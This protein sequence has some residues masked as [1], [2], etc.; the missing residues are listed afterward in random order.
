M[1]KL[2]TWLWSVGGLAAVAAA[3]CALVAALAA[4]ARPTAGAWTKLR[5]GRRQL[6]E[7]SLA[8]T[9]TATLHV[10]YAQGRHDAGHLARPDRASG[11][12]GA[13][14]PDRAGLGGRREPGRRRDPDGAC[15][16]SGAGIRSLDPTKTNDAL[17]T[18]VG[19]GGADSTW[20]LQP[21]RV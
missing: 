8:R 12:V 16:P 9:A 5:T 17:N 14:T 10:V 21:G 18:G 13:A 6:Y 3:A 11:K 20:T 15:A 1:L 2:A 19:A 7:A 4:D